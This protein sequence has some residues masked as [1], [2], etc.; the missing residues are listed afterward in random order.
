MLGTQYG[1]GIPA[2]ARQIVPQGEA[3]RLA[4]SVV[5]AP[6]E[7][8]AQAMASVAQVMNA[9]PS[10]VQ[11][12]DGSYASPRAILGKQLMAGRMTPLELS[13]VVDFGSD[14]AKL[15]RVTAALNDPT[16]GK[17]LPKG[18]DN[19]VAA[20]VRG[21]LQPFLTSVQ[22]LPGAAALAEA[23]VDR[24]IL[25]AKSLMASQ[26]LAVGPAARAAAA[27]MTDGYKYADGYRIP[28]GVAGTMSLG[29]TGVQTGEGLVR[30]GAGQMMAQLTANKGAALYAPAGGDPDTQ[31]GVYADQV[32]HMGRWVTT[33]DDAGVALMVPHPD[34]SWDQVADRY[35]RPVRASWGELQNVA[36]GHGQPSFLQAPANAVKGPDG[37]PMPAVSKQSAM[38]A[39]SWAV[40]GQESRF[41][42]GLV[43]P[44]GALG[45][46]QVTPA[47]VQ[48]YA[49]RLGLPVDLDR[50]QHDDAYNRQIGNAAL[51]DHINHFGASGP[52]LGLALAAYN[53][54]RG[55]VEGYT[56]QAGY[57]PGYIQQ[58]GDPR[59]GQISLDAWVNKLPAETRGY[60]QHVLPAALGKLQGRG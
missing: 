14:P 35:G 13:A 49:P 40:N 41:Q 26:H 19:Q 32:Q 28:D 2:A 42:S 48:T 3:A 1:A 47:T 15:G 5:S 33:P 54:G 20:Q 38:G 4:A 24:T 10:T 57:H 8:R 11:L 43:S 18:E 44:K 27:D 30:N 7:Q 21:A 39:V 23:R 25:V 46:M 34:G 53:A 45:Q 56:D 22:P 37:Q 52:G 55:K 16:V 9:L 6:P 29:L 50:A 31:R 58:Y 17:G 60:I 59:T 12:P 51:A 36:Q